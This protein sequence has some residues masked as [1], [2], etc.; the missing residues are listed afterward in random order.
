MPG[1]RY[2]GPTITAPYGNYSFL[3]DVQTPPGKE[4]AWDRPVD[5]NYE[6]L[7]PVEATLPF[8]PGVHKACRPP[9]PHAEWMK[10]KAGSTSNAFFG[11]AIPPSLSPSSQAKDCND[12]DEEL[13]F[14]VDD[15][16]ESGSSSLLDGYDSDTGPPS[17]A[18]ICNTLQVG[19][20]HI[21]SPPWPRS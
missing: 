9:Q 3:Q 4:P 8:A 6:H 10:G 19:T 11:P 12:Y 16:I 13:A 1:L 14:L 21:L 18:K 2:P 17:I 7:P 20:S 15:F 5:L